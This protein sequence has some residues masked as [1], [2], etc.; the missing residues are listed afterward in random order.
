MGTFTS[1]RRARADRPG[2][3]VA[4]RRLLGST[5]AAALL[6]GGLTALGAPA[7]TAA[8]TPPPV[9]PRDGNVVT[10]DPIP[11]VQ[12]DNGYVW[13]QTMI[14]STVYA[15]GKFDNAREP[16][17]APGTKLTARSNV[18]AY[19][20]E[21]GQLLPFAPKVNGVVKAVAASP[22]GTRIY[23]GGSFNQ[24]NGKGRSNFAALDAKT[25]EPIPGYAPAVGGSGV[26]A[27][28]V[29][30]N[31]VFLGGLF[32]QVNGTARKNLAALDPA[33]GAL[34][35][36]APTTDLQ[37]D[38]MVSDPN[39]TKLIVGGRFSQ[40]NGDGS[41]R[42]V[43]ALSKSTGAVDT[44]WQ[45]NRTVK[46][47]SPAGKAGIFSLNADATG[48]YG[49]GWANSGDVNVS[50]LEGTFAAEAGSGQLRWIADCLGDHYGVY[51]T[52]KVV[53]TTS[54][55]HAC[56][57]M[58]MHPEQKPTVH[59]YS[60]AYTVD[61]RGTLG[62]QMSPA[63]QYKNWEGTPAPSAYHWMPDWAVGTT[64]GLGQAGLSITG[65]GSMI[66]IGGEFRSVNNGQFEG[67]VR[68]STTPP[69][70][71]KDKPRLSGAN[72]PAT[73]IAVPGASGG[74]T[75]TVAANWD[76]DDQTLSYGL[77]RSG[78]ASPVATT[79]SASTW[80]NRPQIRLVDSSAP[81]DASLQYTVVAKDAAGNTASTP[82][83]SVQT[84]AAPGDRFPAGDVGIVARQ[85]SKAIALT[86]G[87]IALQESNG[88][89]PQRWTPVALGD[90]SYQLKNKE[91]GTCLSIDG[92]L[93][94]DG[95]RAISWGCA[96][97]GHF[98]W[99]PKPLGN[100]Y[101]Q[102]VAGHSGKCLTVEGR[103]AVGGARL[104][105]LPCSDASD[106]AQQFA[107]GPTGQVTLVAKH[108]NKVVGIN[109]RGL[110][111]QQENRDTMA[112]RWLLVPQDAGQFQL[113]NKQ[114]GQCASV[115]G[116]LAN[117]GQRVIPW[118][119]TAQAHFFWTRTDAGGGYSYLTAGHTGLC[120][121]V[122]GSRTDNGAPL[123]QTA[124]STAQNGS[125][126]FQLRSVR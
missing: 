96:N 126:Q 67:L 84:S 125:G 91:S 86:G 102:L 31:N 29:G 17:A 121:A 37:V 112:Q 43:A 49:T 10:S 33:T 97:E 87:Q 45:V 85:S 82:T 118:Q 93:Q 41:Q 46:N 13:A 32:T 77:Y 75:V 65:N 8:A 92:Q 89:V 106:V 21:T 90:G 100:G 2:A 64:S 40:V 55:T 88:L 111:V 73:A 123:Q 113:Q 57:T 69:N 52:G 20:I 79:S 19:D 7:A 30:N 117:D 42:G 34:Q 1:S 78:T 119:C 36:W 120:M 80:W 62:R 99:T 98:R 11:T 22:D 27:L 74:V 101:A 122:A 26:Y 47:G 105:Q 25:G 16:L 108:S 15:V 114:T 50:N 116:A 14:G 35:P 107:F 23:I 95:T 63:P 28:S 68:F 83:L 4:L 53:Y 59:R 44:S 104:V 61:A 5:A 81:R 18:L 115:D 39:K 103:N 48:V 70:G 9:L 6:V 56:E 109:D 3:R 58:G 124:C 76:R 60:E 94:N 71:S 51:S 24:V 110:L 12:I 38:A 66:S 72:W 54:H